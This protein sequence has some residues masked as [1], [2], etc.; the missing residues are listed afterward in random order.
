MSVS[1]AILVAGIFQEVVLTEFQSQRTGIKGRGNEKLSLIYRFMMYGK[2]NIVMIEMQI[3]WV[4]T[5]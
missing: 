5:T 2:I 3:L 1:K 4:T